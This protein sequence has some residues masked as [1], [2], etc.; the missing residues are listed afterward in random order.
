MSGKAHRTTDTIHTTGTA[1]RVASPERIRERAS[2]CSTLH[3][4]GEGTT[5]FARWPRRRRTRRTKR[6][7]RFVFSCS[8]PSWPSV[9]GRRGEGRGPCD[10]AKESCCR[11]AP[12]CAHEALTLASLCYRTGASKNVILPRLA[13]YRLRNPH[14]IRLNVKSKPFHWTTRNLPKMSAGFISSQAAG[15]EPRRTRSR[16]WPRRVR[17]GSAEK[18][19]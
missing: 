6:T 16:N 9:L 4:R 3:I 15:K 5:W 2:R 17:C 18:S 10:R 8:Y 7:R 14:R 1:G 12:E 19:K 13:R 11:G